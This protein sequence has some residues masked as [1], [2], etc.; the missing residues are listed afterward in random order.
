VARL[1]GTLGGEKLI[2]SNNA[3]KFSCTFSLFK[4]KPLKNTYLF[5]KGAYSKI[6]KGVL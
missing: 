1:G 6:L 5:N 2:L 3:I 4:E